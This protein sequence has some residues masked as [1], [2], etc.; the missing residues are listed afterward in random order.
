[1]INFWYNSGHRQ[2]SQ[3]KYF[4]P[5]AQTSHFWQNIQSFS[6]EQHYNAIIAKIKFF[7]LWLISPALKGSFP[8][9][10][11]F[12]TKT[13][14]KQLLLSSGQI[15]AGYFWLTPNL[16]CARVRRS[17]LSSLSFLFLLPPFIIQSVHYK[18]ISTTY[19]V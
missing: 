13:L 18:T 16:S 19:V 2:L 6:W 4:S 8:L 1:M 10:P 12:R 7:L 9:P 5:F 11:T 15:F 14:R 17:L 3:T